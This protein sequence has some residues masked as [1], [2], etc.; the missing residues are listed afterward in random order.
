MK[1][2]LS[3]IIIGLI[4]LTACEKKVDEDPIKILINSNKNA[5][6]VNSATFHLVYSYRETKNEHITKV[7]VFIKRI[8]RKEYPFNLRFEYD[9][10][11][12][13]TYNGDQFR[14]YDKV[15]NKLTYVEKE[16]EPLRFVDGNWIDQAINMIVNETDNSEQI[17]KSTDTIGKPL[18]VKIDG[19]DFILINKRN[20]FQEYDVLVNSNRFYNPDNYLCLI[21]SSIQIATGDTIKM[22]YKI[23]NLIIDKDISNDK[24]NLKP[25][26][27]VELV[28]YEPVQQLETIEVGK[29]APDFELMSGDG[30][31]VTLKSLRGKVVL[32]DFWGTWC[33]WC[34]KAMPKL[35][36]LRKEFENNS[37]VVIL[38]IS[39]QEPDNAD[40]V[41]FMKDKN[42]NYR[43]LLKGDETSK[44]FGVN[45]FP[46][47]FLIDQ[48]GKIGY[49]VIGY[50]E[51]LKT[52]LSTEIK[53][54]FK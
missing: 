35:E 54:N 31:K 8:E 12:V 26:S 53:K 7:K 14:W 10:G 51:E 33:V 23:T 2:I 48:N 24:F 34:V 22:V 19:S 52:I 43:T 6:K 5:Q 47:L 30:K 40:P 36:E 41:K 17:K 1:K 27:G 18:M 13:A 38:G 20:Y 50:S 45:G 28:R 9:D 49:K 4:I 21:D 11:T 46:T 3:L 15:S 29:L 42:I 44:D 25:N 37:K 16:N 32:L 39:C